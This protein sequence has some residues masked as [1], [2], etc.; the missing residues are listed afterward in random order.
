MHSSVV[1][2][3]S[4]VLLLFIGIPFILGFHRGGHRELPFITWH[5]RSSVVMITVFAA[6]C[7]FFKYFFYVSNATQPHVPLM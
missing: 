5:G 7:F 2:A 3:I 1:I 6:F 4:K